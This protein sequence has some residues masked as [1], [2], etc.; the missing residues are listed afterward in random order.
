MYQLKIKRNIKN[1]NL[2]GNCNN[3]IDK[4]KEEKLQLTARRVLFTRN[5]IYYFKEIFM[6]YPSYLLQLIQNL[7]LFPGVGN[8]TAERFAFELL[9]WPKE[10]QEALGSSIQKIQNLLNYCTKCGCLLDTSKPCL[11]CDTSTRSSNSI[12]V[13]AFAKDIFS[14]EQTREFSGLY[15]VLGGILSPMDNKGPE[16]LSLEKL[17]NRIDKLKIKEVIIAIDATLEGD[18]TSLY[19]KKEIEQ[20]SFSI[21]ISRL[22]FGLPMGSPF[23]YA[24]NGTLARSFLGRQKF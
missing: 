22:A 15:H 9:N 10:K 13:V 1:I 12:C 4:K 23:E 19:I 21:S 5:K 14:I 18:A 8:K 7:K 24:D 16:S 3:Y 17:K 11:Y 20:L 6:N 2:I